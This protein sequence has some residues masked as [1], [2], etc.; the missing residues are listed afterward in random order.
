M[1]TVREHLEKDDTLENRTTLNPD[2]ICQLLDLCLNT[3][4]F[5][6]NGKFYRQKH[7]CAMG[8]PVSPIVANLY[9]ERV[10][11]KALNSYQGTPP[12]HWFRYVDDTWVKIKIQD[13]HPFTEHINSV[14]K[15]IKFTREDVK[16]NHLPFLDCN[17]HIDEDRSL[18][19]G[20]YM[21]PTHTNR[22]HHTR[23]D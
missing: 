18:Q 8:S 12:S 15:N 17:V 13:L 3:T 9:V 20:L 16:D 4:Y 22:G 1:E 19:S 11:Q 23:W 10:E 2:Q 21:K 14:D 5:Q 7:G 6:F